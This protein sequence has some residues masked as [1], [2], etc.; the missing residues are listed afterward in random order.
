MNNYKCVA[1]DMIL[2]LQDDYDILEF[3][4]VQFEETFKKTILMHDA[5]ENMLN[6]KI[7]ASLS[8]F[9]VPFG[10]SDSKFF[11]CLI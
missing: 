5:Q 4:K 2:V 3:K 7:E 6:G 9:W 1:F 10:W 8:N 11:V